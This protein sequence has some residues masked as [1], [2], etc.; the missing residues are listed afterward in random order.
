MV[1]TAYLDEEQLFDLDTVS[2]MNAMKQNS[3]IFAC[4][5]QKSD[6]LFFFN[7]ET[8]TQC[9]KTFS[10]DVFLS[11]NCKSKTE[12]IVT[13]FDC[14]DKN[15]G[16][17]VACYNNNLINIFNLSKPSQPQTVFGNCSSSSQK[18]QI[19]TDVKWHP[20]VD[21]LFGTS[22]TD[23]SFQLWDM[24]SRGKDKPS[25]N[26][27]A[28]TEATT[29]VSFSKFDE[30]LLVTGSKDRSI[31]LWDMRNLKLKIHSL[32]GHVHCVEKVR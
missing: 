27:R 29:S 19:C 24:R 17:V 13:G 15:A 31:A 7:H 3:N 10:P 28:H 5:T 16:I 11:L 6:S 1:I 26:V 14:S 32:T 25:S 12:N 30:T 8:N 20:F 22:S 21:T 2:R 9:L 4:S 23:G 18:T